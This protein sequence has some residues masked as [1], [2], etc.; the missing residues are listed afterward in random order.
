MERKVVDVDAAGDVL[1]HDYQIMHGVEVTRG[2]RYSLAI[3]FSDSQSSVKAGTTPWIPRLA[4]EGNVFA[5]YLNGCA[6]RSGT[7]GIPKSSEQAAHWFSFAAERGHAISKYNLGLLHC[8]GDGVVRDPSRCVELWES[9][10]AQGLACA[11]NDLGTAWKQGYLGLDVD[12][13][14]AKKY[15]RLAAAQGYSLSQAILADETRW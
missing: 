4:L 12:R 6:Y 2:C 13:D 10:A 8:K 15:Y 3:W 14:V 5:A 11:Q 7:F 9:A 1:V